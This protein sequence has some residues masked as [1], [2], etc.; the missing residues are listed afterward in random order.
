MGIGGPFLGRYL[1]DVSVT[2]LANS[3][4]LRSKL[5][6]ATLCFWFDN[7]P[8]LNLEISGEQPFYLQVGFNDLLLQ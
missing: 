8:Y 4:H 7:C 5:T 1:C 6:N 2:S 3:C